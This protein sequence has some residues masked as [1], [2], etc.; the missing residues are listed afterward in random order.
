MMADSMEAVYNKKFLGTPGW[1]KE[2]ME[3]G[4]VVEYNRGLLRLFGD[5]LGAPEDTSTKDD[6]IKNLVYLI[7]GIKPRVEGSRGRPPKNLV[8]GVTKPLLKSRRDIERGVTVYYLDEETAPDEDLLR[9]YN[10]YKKDK[11]RSTV[12]LMAVSIRQFYRVMLGYRKREL[13]DIVKNIVPPSVDNK[14]IKEY[15]TAKETIAI[16]NAATNPRDR[17]LLSGNYET[18]TGS[19]PDKEWLSL[20]IGDIRIEKNV[21]YVTIRES[22]TRP[23]IT[24]IKKFVGDLKL[25][26]NMHPDGAN[27]AAYVWCVLHG[28]N[29]GRRMGYGN[30]DR[31]LKSACRKAGTKPYAFRAFRHRRAKDLESVLSIREKMAYMGWTSIQTAQIYGNFTS[32]ESCETIVANEEGRPRR[33]ESDELLSWICGGCKSVN[34]CTNSFC[35][36]CG[37]RK[38][39]VE[40][41]QRIKVEKLIDLFLELATRDEVIRGR[42][43]ELLT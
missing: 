5:R 13:P 6:Y 30:A 7:E 31:I 43:E 4:G 20:K 29:Y 10:G 24:V 41:L 26:L 37:G 38:N 42:M 33:N 15:P 9:F 14:D 2:Q 34:P 27:E 32:E 25:W 18:A 12:K 16:I 8:A 40:P 19:R 22:K 21:A 39:D 36:V 28:Q 11:K 17:A 3:G 35:G 23:R 1:G